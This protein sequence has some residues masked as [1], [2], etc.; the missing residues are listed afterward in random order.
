MKC[1]EGLLTLEPFQEL[2]QARLEWACDRAKEL[3]LPE[4]KTI[5]E[6]GDDPNGFFLLL[7]GRVSITRMSEGVEMPIGQHEAPAFFGEI[8][9][10]MEAPVLVSIRTL[11]D[12]CLYQIDC[13]DFLTLLHECRGFER[14]IFRVVQQRSRGLES[15]IRSREKMAALGTLS[16]GLAHELNNP[17]SALVR[18]LRDVVPTIRELER[19]NLTYGQQNPDP[20]HTQD[21][22]DTRDRGYDAILNQTVDAMTLSDRED[23]L[24]DWLEDYGVNDAWKLT[25]PLAAAGTEISALERLTERW[26]DNSTELR[27]MGVRWLA[28]SFDMMSMLNNGLRGA[29]RIAEL[30]GSMKSY[31]H[32]DRGAQQ[33]VDVHD[34][35]EDTLKLFSY[36]LKH[37]IKV[38][39]KYDRTLP[40]ILAY[41]SELNQVWT[42]LIDN[43]IDAMDEKGVLEI[44]T[45]RDRNYVRVEIVDS[46]SGIPPEIQCRI[47]EPFFTTKDMGKGSGLGLD[48]V[49]RIVTNRHQGTVTLTSNPGQTRLIVC[50]PIPDK[51]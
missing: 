17:A 39:R 3:Q 43:A 36:K 51:T 24:L 25:E 22:Q 41:G 19:M 11:T 49:N 38:C 8:P 2:P 37:G 42:N 30:V 48:A 45:C 26:R 46:G 1:I 5:V 4:G 9:V 15:F 47:F 50:L 6:E 40:K 13:C 33:F 10:L 16:A 7:K 29:D 23:E 18:A 20:K 27:D 35:L 14:S 32:L 12:C 44:L 31:S 21:W 34:G 28:L